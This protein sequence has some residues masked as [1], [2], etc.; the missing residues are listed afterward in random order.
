LVDYKDNNNTDVNIN[1]N[2]KT[3]RK[4]F[5]TSKTFD[6]DKDQALLTH[7]DK[8]FLNLKQQELAKE[9]LQ[10]YVD[11]DNLYTFKNIY[12]QQGKETFILLNLPQD[13]QAFNDFIRRTYKPVLTSQHGVMGYT[14]YKVYFT[15]TLQSVNQIIN[16]VTAVFVESGFTAVKMQIMFCVIW[17]G[18]TIEAENH[19]II[20]SYTKVLID[21]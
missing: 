9:F 4:R 13:K 1:I 2:T 15:N 21:S 6:D 14:N 8:T 18:P 16:E 10:K 7:G 19:E 20:S 17:E 11:N 3:K 5:E 12:E